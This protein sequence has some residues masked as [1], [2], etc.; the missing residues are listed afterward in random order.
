MRPERPSL[1]YHYSPTRSAKEALSVL[2]GFQGYLPSDAYA[3]QGVV[4]QKAD[5]YNVYCMA[6][7]RR[8]FFK[9]FNT[10]KR[11]KGLSYW[12]IQQIQKLQHLESDCKK[13]K[14]CPDTIRERPLAEAKPVLEAIHTKLEAASL[15]NRRRGQKTM[16]L[17]FASFINR[18]RIFIGDLCFP[19]RLR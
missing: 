6:H 4:A 19:E 8:Y 11:K 17:S 10:S 14:A 13:A 16:T 18:N 9:V 2:E 12:V 5:V 15:P 7:A 3:G 1:L